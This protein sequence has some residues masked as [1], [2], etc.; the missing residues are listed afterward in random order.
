MERRGLGIGGGGGGGEER[1]GGGRI[2][3][4]TF[5]KARSAAPSAMRGRTANAGGIVAVVS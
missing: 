4:E 1:G 2:N 5:I 3:N